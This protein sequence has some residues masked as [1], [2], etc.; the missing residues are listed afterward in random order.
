M[1]GSRKCNWFQLRPFSALTTNLT[2]VVE[3]CHLTYKLRP[4]RESRQHSNR[5]YTYPYIVLANA[6]EQSKR[7]RRLSLEVLTHLHRVGRTSDNEMSN[8]ET[9]NETRRNELHMLAIHS[10]RCTRDLIA[11]VLGPLRWLR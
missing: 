6:G 5:R 8:A 4:L 7:E 11:P 3:G 9:K 10:L 1:I 2:E